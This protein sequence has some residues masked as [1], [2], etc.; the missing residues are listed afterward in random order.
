ML[1]KLGKAH[2]IIFFG[3]VHRPSKVEVLS[4]EPTKITP[5]RVYFEPSS[6]TAF[7]DFVENTWAF[8]SL[9][10]AVERARNE[11]WDQ[12]RLS[13]SYIDDL[14]RCMSDLPKVKNGS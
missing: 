11:I 9:G 5:K 7:R 8:D 2:V 4:V 1:T 14:R 12:I 6:K 3:P 10:E 13:E